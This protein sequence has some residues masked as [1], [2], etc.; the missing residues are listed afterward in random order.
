MLLSAAR[1]IAFALVLAV[2]PSVPGAG[3]SAPVAP[4]L[5]AATLA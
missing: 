1:P 5:K 2:L 3:E 4:G